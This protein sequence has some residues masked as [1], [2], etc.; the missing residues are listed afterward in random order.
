MLH[1]DWRAPELS[2]ETFGN[3]GRRWL[4]AGL[5]R[6]GAPL[7]PRTRELYEGHWK[8]WLEPH[9]GDVALGALTPERW[10]SWFV[11]QTS[12]KP[13][14]TQPGKAYKLARV[15]LNQAVDDGLIRSNPCHIKG[16]GRDRSPERPIAT[17][18]QVANI[19]GAIEQRYRAMVLLAAYCSLR[20]GELAGLRRRDIDVLHRTVRVE[21]QA[22]E[23]AGGR[24][25]FTKPKAESMRTVAIPSPLMSALEAHVAAYVGPEPSALVFT[26]ANGLPMRR[27]QFVHTW[28]RACRRAGVE[29]IHFHDLRGSGATWAAQT[30]ATVAELM[31]RLGHRTP[32]VAM[33]YQ[34]ATLER[35]QAIAARL[36]DLMQL[37]SETRSNVLP[38]DGH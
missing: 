12:K 30:G 28:R 11:E 16:A 2:G 18:G 9:F 8:L 5:G 3:F 29:P 26:S 7:A 20:F 38:L 15:I 24:I 32:T 14:S 21:R 19:A 37:E 1:G 13:D 22:I 34:H 6:V 33:Q 25:E 31:Q 10:R 27:T 4:D 36:G 35:D 23:L 17:P